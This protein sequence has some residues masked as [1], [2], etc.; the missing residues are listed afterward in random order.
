MKGWSTTEKSQEIESVNDAWFRGY[1][2]DSHDNWDGRTWTRNFAELCTRDIAIMSLGELKDKRILDVGCGDGTY[3]FALSKLGSNVSGQDLSAERIT[4]AT[5]RVYGLGN[6]LMGRFVCGDA[7]NLMFDSETFDAV[8]SADFF[9]HI[10]LS[11]KREVLA[12]IYRVLKPGGVL[13]IKT[14]NLDYLR[15][16]INVRRILNLIRLRSPLVFI[17]HTKN[18]PDNEHVGLTNYREMRDELEALFFHTPTFHHHILRRKKLPRF[19][20]NFL[21]FFRL[22]P[23]S[24]HLIISTRKSIFVG[25]ADNL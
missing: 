24:E 17:A 14:P 21:Y 3:A 15:I 6:N 13:V 8:F 11:K 20:S 12:E 25:I 9:E 1:Y 22:K 7:S 10:S 19:I 2:T 23:L 16:S 4:Q 18:N 5:Q